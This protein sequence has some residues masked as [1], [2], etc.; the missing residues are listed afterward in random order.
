MS[1]N[2]IHRR[3]TPSGPLGEE[4]RAHCGRMTNVGMKGGA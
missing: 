1:K 4:Y 2:T 3:L